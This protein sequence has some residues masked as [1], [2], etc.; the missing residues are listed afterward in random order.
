M[1]FGL[2]EE[3]NKLIKEI[4]SKYGYIMKIFGSRATGKYRNN[5]DIDIAVFGEV[6][7]KDKFNIMNDFDLLEIPYKIDLVF[8]SELVKTE[9]IKEIETKGVE[10]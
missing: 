1:R 7:E 9:L 3:T 10:I 6:S 5:S 2:S 4:A 8:V